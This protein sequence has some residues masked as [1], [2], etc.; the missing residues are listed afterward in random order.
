MTV[1]LGYIVNRW[2]ASSMAVSEEF[3][4]VLPRAYLAPFL[5]LWQVGN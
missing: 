5:N 2:I 1:S 3:L 4:T